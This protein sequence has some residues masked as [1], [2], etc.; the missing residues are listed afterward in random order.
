MESC[1]K[2]QTSLWHQLLQDQLLGHLVLPDQNPT[3]RWQE[4][5]AYDQTRRNWHSWHDL[6]GWVP[7]SNC[8]PWNN[9]TAPIALGA[10][11]HASWQSAWRVMF[12]K[13]ELRTKTGNIYE[14]RRAS[15]SSCH[16]LVWILSCIVTNFYSFSH[17]LLTDNIP[18]SLSPDL[19]N[20]LPHL[21]SCQQ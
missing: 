16:F 20:L 9:L 2:S 15:S 13:Q 11:S 6:S 14:Q 12:T 1:W 7:F 18:L 19:Q 5:T 4:I 17:N 10:T 8:F 3:K 21:S